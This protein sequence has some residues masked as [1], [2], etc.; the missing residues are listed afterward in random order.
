MAAS[1]ALGVF[2]FEDFE[3]PV[4]TVD[5]LTFFAVDRRKHTGSNVQLKR[6]FRGKH[7]R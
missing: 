2:R 6:P 1:R 5:V 7:V 3:P 4:S